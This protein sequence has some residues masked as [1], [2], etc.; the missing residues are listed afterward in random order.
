MYGNLKNYACIAERLYFYVRLCNA[1][2]SS[3]YKNV[4]RKK[5][6]SL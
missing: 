5:N 4:W 1:D 3:T 2:F 6:F